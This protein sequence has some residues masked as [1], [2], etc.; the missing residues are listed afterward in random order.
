VIWLVIAAAL[1]RTFI[2]SDQPAA[3]NAVIA[4]SRLRDEASRKAGS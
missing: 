1:S 2:A 3:Q 4:A